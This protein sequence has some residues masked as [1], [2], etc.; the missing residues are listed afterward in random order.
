MR[1]AEAVK[2][3]RMVERTIA[4]NTPLYRCAREQAVV[5]LDRFLEEYEAVRESAL[6]ADE[7]DSGCGFVND[8]ALVMQAMKAIQL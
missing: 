8:E 5:L 4:K 7:E 2:N 1:L 6:L 3:L